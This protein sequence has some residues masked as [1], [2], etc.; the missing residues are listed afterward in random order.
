MNL[1]Q[2]LHIFSQDWK[3]SHSKTNQK[4][5]DGAREE[6]LGGKNCQSADGERSEQNFY[7]PHLSDWLKMRLHSL[8]ANFSNFQPR[9]KNKDRG[10]LFLA[11]TDMIMRL[12]G[13]TGTKTMHLALLKSCSCEEVHSQLRG[14]ECKEQLQNNART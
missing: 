3:R 11:H 9:G 2:I 12:N 4:Y 8:K 6:M 7:G 14:N 1:L 13:N 5:R 10:S